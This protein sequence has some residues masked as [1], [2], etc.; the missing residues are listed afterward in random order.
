MRRPQALLS[1]VLALTLLALPAEAADYNVDVSLRGS[2]TSMLRQNNV[3]K[4]L[5]YSFVENPAQLAELVEEGK[6]VRLPGNEHYRVISGV[7]YPFARPEV[8]LFIERLAEQYFEGTGEQLVV[9]SLVRP[10]SQQPRNSHELSVHPAGIAIDL[11]I[12]DKKLSRAWLE[13]VLLRLERQG[14][15]DITRERWPPHYHVAIFPSSYRAYVEEMIG[16]DEVAA[17]M[18]YDVEP[19]EPEVAV[20][21]ASA[22]PEPAKTAATAVPAVESEKPA[23]R[24]LFAALPLSALVFFLLG[25]WRGRR[26][27]DEDGGEVLMESNA[28]NGR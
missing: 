25:Y 24:L 12:S 4:E 13:S 14:V 27:P 17:A 22:A 15:L 1:A 11:R 8:R 6:F 20:A 19:E 28:S 10:R 2:P 16:P 3:A 5:G 18:K 9:T 23:K 7:S 26:E 21:E